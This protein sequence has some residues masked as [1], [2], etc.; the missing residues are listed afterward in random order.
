MTDP[1]DSAPLHGYPHQEVAQNP[2]GRHVPEHDRPVT[3]EM[4]EEELT[5]RLKISHLEKVER[6]PSSDPVYQQL[7]ERLTA[8]EA[9]KEKAQVIY[10]RDEFAREDQKKIAELTERNATLERIVSLFLGGVIAGGRGFDEVKMYAAY[11]T[12]VNAGCKRSAS[13]NLP[14]I[15]CQS[16]EEES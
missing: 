6:H 5:L 13:S 16:E 15:V 11:R 7:R 14:V 2:E 10:A 8:I 9:M 1:S 4:P 3:V 12:A